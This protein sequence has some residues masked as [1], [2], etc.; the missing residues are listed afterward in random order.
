MQ[1][2]QPSCA[3]ALRR[4]GRVPRDLRGFTLIELMIGMVIG[5]M[6][7]LA[8]SIVVVKFEG[9]R[10]TTATSSD[11]QVSGAM[12]MD[13]IQRHVMSAGYGFT[14]VAGLIGCSL[15]AVHKGIPVQ[16]PKRLVPV[17]ITTAPGKPDKLRVFYSGKTSFSVPVRIKE[18]YNPLDAANRLRFRVTS[19]LG[20]A[21]PKAGVYSGD[22]MLVGSSAA[23]PCQVFRASAIV[24]AEEISRADES[25]GWNATAPIFPSKAYSKDDFLV[26]L[27]TPRDF[28]FSISDKK[29]LV[30]SELKVA[31]DGTPTYQQPYELASNVVDMRVFYGKDTTLPDA[32]GSIDEWSADPPG[33]GNAWQ[34]VLA[35]RLAIVTRSAQF[36]REDVT[37]EVPYWDLG[38]TVPTKAA[39]VTLCEGRPCVGFRTDD[40]SD[41]KRYRYKVLETVI[42]MRNLVWKTTT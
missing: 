39:D 12:A 9:M 3:D 29:S 2:R 31:T 14:Q 36:E 22:L 21:P 5:L 33:N 35:V 41:W 8:V 27:G 28:E 32:D 19:N 15:E 16:L 25:A 11:A 18:D 38:T 17:E 26:N 24:G 7:T 13:S 37:K 20:V 4:P 30:V 42:P 6:T 10:R 40:V 23:V 1:Y 34:R